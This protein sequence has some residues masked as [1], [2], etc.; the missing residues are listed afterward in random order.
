MFKPH[1]RT[2][3]SHPLLILVIALISQ[4]SRVSRLPAETQ[5]QLW[6]EKGLDEGTVTGK[7]MEDDAAAARHVLVPLAEL[8]L[9]REGTP[10]GGIAGWAFKVNATTKERRFLGSLNVA[11]WL[12]SGC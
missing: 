3:S 5:T 2:P 9:R 12:V 4:G 11:S 8:P 7:G 1:S 6:G 10:G